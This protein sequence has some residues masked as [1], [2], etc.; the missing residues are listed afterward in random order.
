MLF[1]G[2]TAE[3][4]YEEG[5]TAVMKGDL[6]Q[7]ARHLT[8]AL[9]LDASMYGAHHQLGKCRMRQGRMKEAVQ[10]LEKAT[11]NLPELAPPH[12]DLGFALL[13]L[14]NIDNA[15]EQ[16]SAALQIK[17]DDARA[18]L[19]LGY[20]AFERQQWETAAG[21]VSRALELGR[22]H[23]DA[24][25]LLAQ[26]LDR[27]GMLE[28]AMPHFKKALEL[29]DQSIETNPE[30]PTGYYLRGSVYFLLQHFVNARQDFEA[31][32]ERA[33]HERHYA[34]YHHHFNYCD[35][36]AMLGRCLLKLGKSDDAAR[37]GQDILTLAPDH[38]VG[39]ELAHTRDAT[40]S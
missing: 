1:G 5:V 25:F 22:I 2:E 29:M 37:I 38:P 36:L 9:E 14:N 30:Q 33:D 7:A 31:A 19:G 18:V 35:I 34:A 21:L 8:R 3:S 26:A 28:E 17:S 10:H 27:A 13:T 39:R 12:V 16:F 15:R 11:R 6:D 4:Y 20:C 24:H 23:F 32:R 40:E